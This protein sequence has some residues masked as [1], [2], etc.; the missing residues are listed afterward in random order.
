[1]ESVVLARLKLA[2]YDAS[3]ERHVFSAPMMVLFAA[4]GAALTGALAQI[5][6]PLWFTPIPVTGQVLAVLLCG[7]LLG[8]GYGLLSQALFIAAGLA[9]V[10]WL[11]GGKVGMAALLMPSTGYL[12]G[13][14]AAAFYVGLGTRAG[15]WARTLQGQIVIMLGGA[16]II[17]FFGAT[18]LM[19]TLG[20]TPL[21]AACVGVLPFVAV[22]VVKAVMAAMLTSAVLPK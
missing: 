1:M 8:S 19:L 14:M 10:P 5:R 6:L 2:R 18:Y 11:A 15:A 3:A 22:D 12:V 7:S 13:F 4:G 21:E 16:A 9:G 17:L 20:L